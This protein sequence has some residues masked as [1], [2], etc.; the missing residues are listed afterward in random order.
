MMKQPV[1]TLPDSTKPFVLTTDASGYAVGAT[2]SQDQGDG[3]RPIA[4]LSKKMN[5][6]EI[7]YPVHEQELLA[8]IISMSTW[9]QYLHG[10]PFTL[11][12]LTDHHSLQWLKSQPHLSQRQTRWVEKIAEYDIIIEY[13]EGKK[14]VVADALSRRPDHRN[15]ESPATASSSLTSITESIAVPS[16]HLL[17]RLKASYLI[18]PLC[19][20]ILKDPTKHPEYTIDP[21]GLI[22]RDG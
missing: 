11:R 10:N 2:L 17:V 14:N 16:N 20:S 13:Q 9:R 3:L 5:N 1:L 15:I 21:E 22:H 19:Q 8:I 6:H 7:N 18:D 4:Y 12:V